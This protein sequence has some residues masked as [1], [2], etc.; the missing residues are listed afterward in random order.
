MPDPAFLDVETVL[1]LYDDMREDYGVG[2]VSID[3]CKIEGALGRV[4]SNF[5]YLDPAPSVPSL[6]GVLGY[7]LAKAHAFGD[8][9]KRT[10]LAAMDL[11]LMDNGWLNIADGIETAKML[12]AVVGNEISEAEFIQWIAAN[13]T[14]DFATY[15]MD[16]FEDDD[17]F[18]NGNA[19]YEILPLPVNKDAAN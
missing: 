4:E 17:E 19:L 13:C 8:G 9:N 11:F 18:E 16:E 15:P 1:A 12:E 10:A 5:Y 14:D 6:A 7:S 2:L 3:E